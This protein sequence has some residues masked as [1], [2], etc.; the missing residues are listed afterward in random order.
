[1]KELAYNPLE[2]ERPEIVID[3]NDGTEDLVS[4]II[5]HKDRPEYLNICLQ[6]ISVTSINNN[7]E[8]II[9][10]NGSTDKN[11]I[12]FLESLSNDPNIKII[13]NE[14]NRWW[15]AAA[16]QGV[17]VADKNSKY[18]IFLHCDVVILSGSW[19]DVLIN[20]SELNKSGCIGL[21][22]GN[23]QI[24]KN[25]VGYIQEWCLLVSR[26]CWN[27][28]GPFC[29]E[30]PQIGSPFIFT[31]KSANKGYNPQIVSK[32][33]LAFHYKIFSLDYSEYER[34]GEQAQIVIPKIYMEISKK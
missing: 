29:E 26:N 25:K 27:D 14:T 22:S 23:Y 12:D 10:D 24:G 18:F 8:I 17:K 21:E 28:C 32:V 1:M 4:I 16:N 5:V 15:S 19:I 34:L 11:A 9:V 20:I 7:Y 13:R 31:L 33:N 3:L 30:L 2:G 6:S